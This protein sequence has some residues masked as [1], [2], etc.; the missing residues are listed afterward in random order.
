[1]KSMSRYCRFCH[2]PYVAETF[3]ARLGRDEPG[4]QLSCKCNDLERRSEEFARLIS[5]KTYK[6]SVKPLEVSRSIGY[7]RF[8][9]VDSLPC[10]FEYEIRL[11]KAL[12]KR[13]LAY[14]RDLQPA[15]VYQELG[16]SSL[17]RYQGK[18]VHSA[19]RLRS[20]TGGEYKIEVSNVKLTEGLFYHTS[21]EA[22][23]DDQVESC[24]G[25][26]VESYLLF[27]CSRFC[28]HMRRYDDGAS[29]SAELEFNQDLYTENVPPTPEDIQDAVNL[30]ME[31]VFSKSM[32]KDVI[33]SRIIPQLFKVAGSVKDVSNLPPGK[34]VYMIKADGEMCWVIVSGMV[35]YL[36][37]NTPALDFYG[38]CVTLPYVNK[39]VGLSAHRCELMPDSRLVYIDRLCHEGTIVWPRREYQRN[40]AEDLIGVPGLVLRKEFSTLEEAEF[41]RCTSDVPSDGVIA[42]E[43]ASS[44]TYRFKRPSL[45]LIVRGE[46]LCYKDGDDIV[47]LVR[48]DQEMIEDMIYECWFDDSL[49]ELCDYKPRLDKVLP[50]S[51]KVVQAV[52]EKNSSGGEVN[53][54]VRRGVT[55]ACFEFRVA[56][57]DWAIKLSGR[58]KIIIDVGTGRNQASQIWD[59]SFSYVMCDPELNVKEVPGWNWITLNTPDDG[60]KYLKWAAAR[61]GR[62]VLCRMK[63][64]DLMTSKVRNYVESNSIP[65]TYM[66]SAGSVVKEIQEYHEA[67]IAQIMCC[68]VY[69]DVNE[70][71]VL[72]EEE[73]GI[74][75]RVTGPETARVIFEPSIDME[76]Y[77]IRTSDFGMC[78]CM[79]HEDVIDCEA[80]TPRTIDVIKHVNVMVLN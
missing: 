37:R 69:D 38:Y 12:S 59:S 80:Y 8:P 67:G 49:S 62:I 36:A 75:M 19:Y 58:T 27:S 17:C 34:Y 68:Y 25:T 3:T 14:V 7:D 29:Y 64:S 47:A 71:G 23:T 76:E 33:P 53:S 24:Y 1:M 70:Y 51:A 60:V 4:V 42:V 50:N 35:T 44:L 21:I 41:E 48:A 20:Y 40:T 32:S 63:V 18:L 26:E 54:I 10:K 9:S 56:V 39:T 55:D 52:I 15:L 43:L 16:C 78:L 79:T 74:S 61:S 30:I 31:M 6:F 65:M 57:H 66:F 72:I 13:L 5:A 11:T 28:L 46:Y 2:L 77:P 22:A 45:D 73:A